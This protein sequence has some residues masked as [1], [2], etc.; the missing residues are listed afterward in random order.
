[1]CSGGRAIR[2]EDDDGLKA[3]DNGLLNIEGQL[4]GFLFFYFSISNV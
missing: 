2:L 4:K 1:M 3:A